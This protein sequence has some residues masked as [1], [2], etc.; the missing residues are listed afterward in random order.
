LIFDILELIPPDFLKEKVK[1]LFLGPKD[2][3][4]MEKIFVPKMNNFFL[5]DKVQIL[6]VKAFN[7]LK[8]YL[9]CK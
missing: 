7:E 1:V 8:G 5:K 4:Y 6:P 2:I 3:D 9:L